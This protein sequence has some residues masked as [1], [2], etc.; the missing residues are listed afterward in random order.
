MNLISFDF[1]DKRTGLVRLRRICV[2][3]LNRIIPAEVVS[4]SEIRS[5]G[6]WLLSADPG[7]TA[8]VMCYFEQFCFL[9]LCEK[10]AALPP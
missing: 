1:G 8:G 9:F 10:E 6:I 7:T 5:A 3:F 2:V 4:V